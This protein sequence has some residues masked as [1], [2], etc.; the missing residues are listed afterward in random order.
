MKPYLLALAVAAAA[1]PACAGSN[2]SAP[3]RAGLPKGCLPPKVEV[4]TDPVEQAADDADVMFAFSPG[5]ESKFPARL[6]FAS[7]KTG[8][9][10]HVYDVPPLA[11]P[12]WQQKLGDRIAGVFNGPRPPPPPPGGEPDL[13]DVQDISNVVQILGRLRM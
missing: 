10:T 5:A 4:A 8:C 9:V 2:L 1:L 6:V 3:Q 7:T 11:I 12:S 13:R